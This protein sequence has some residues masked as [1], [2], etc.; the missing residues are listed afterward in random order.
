[1]ALFRTTAEM[2]SLARARDAEQRERAEALRHRE[3]AMEAE[4]MASK[5]HNEAETIRALSIVF[6]KD[7][8]TVI[9]AKL[10]AK[11]TNLTIGGR[12]GCPIGG[13]AL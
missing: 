12:A 10:V 6:L 7:S 8:E 2:Q 5:A 9:E 1:M 13:R 3:R 11:S 4:R